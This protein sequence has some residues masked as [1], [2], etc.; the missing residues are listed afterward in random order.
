MNR[1]RLATVCIATY[2]RPGLLDRLLGALEGQRLP[3]DLALEVVVVDNDAAGSAKAVAA[4][5]EAAG[6]DLRYDVESEQN[7]SLAR[8]RAV[9]LAHGEL[10]LFIDDDER[11]V[12]TWVAH[13]VATLDD[14]GADLVFGPVLP[15]FAASAPDWITASAYFNRTYPATGEPVQ[16]GGAG[17]CL[18][19]RPQ[20]EQ[21]AGPFDPALG[22]SGGEDTLLFE[23]LGRSGARLVMCREAE[24]R[25]HIPPERMRPRWLIH[26][27]LR[28]GNLYARRSVALADHQRAQRL[29]LGIK[30]FAMLALCAVRTVVAVAPATRARWGLRGVSCL[31]QIIGVLDVRIR[32]Y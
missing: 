27:A 19:R 20:L 30:A 7:I 32:G 16:T 2:R 13:L 25:E 22:H 11:P 12:D 26:R 28:T 6:L 3:E 18:V 15:D 5:W 29:R 9:A 10:V 21:V 1:T 31:G 14:T 23:T 24:V 4:H 17:N 8:N